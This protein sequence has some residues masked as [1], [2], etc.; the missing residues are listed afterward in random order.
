MGLSFH[1]E[2]SMVKASIGSLRLE[3]ANNPNSV[4]EAE[5]ISI[6]GQERRDDDYGDQFTPDSDIQVE[7]R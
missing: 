6:V 2:V 5:N 1:D 4:M 3:F 7:K